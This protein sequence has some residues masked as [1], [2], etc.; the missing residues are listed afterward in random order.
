MSVE[1]CP[2][3]CYNPPS[4]R[5]GARAVKNCFFY[6]RTSLRPVDSAKKPMFLA[7]CVSSDRFYFHPRSSAFNYE[8]S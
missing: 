2:R 3:S 6:E 8:N 5:T 4:I 7:E 1:I